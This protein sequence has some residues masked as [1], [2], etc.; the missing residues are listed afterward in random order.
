MYVGLDSFSYHRF[1]G[2]IS[3]YEPETAIRWQTTDFLNRAVELGVKAVCL[4][5]AFLDKANILSLREPLAA[6]GLEPVLAWGHP[7]GLD[8]GDDASR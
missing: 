5:T 2:D 7:A 4:Q 3:P 1:F 8:D 6:G